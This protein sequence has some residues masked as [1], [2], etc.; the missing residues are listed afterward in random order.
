MKNAY[1][2]SNVNS[3]LVIIKLK[4]KNRIKNKPKSP[5]NFNN[6]IGVKLAVKNKEK[7]V[8]KNKQT[9][10]PINTIKLIGLDLLKKLASIVSFVIFVA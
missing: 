8:N 1:E 10:M 2:L 6:R 7:Q 5:A 3:F 9:K 4:K